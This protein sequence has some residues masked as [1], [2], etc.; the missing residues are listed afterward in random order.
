M[1]V[2]RYD[3]APMSTVTREDQDGFLYTEAVTGRTGVLHYRNADGSARRELRLP[4]EAGSPQTLASMVG[5]PVVVTHSG[6][7]VNKRTAKS[8]TV[9]TLISARFDNGLTYNSMVIHDAA[10]QQAAKTTHPELSQG[11]RLDLEE[12]SGYY[13]AAA[14]EISDTP[15]QGFEPFDYIQRNLRV[16]HLALVPKG[17]AGAVARL[18][19]DGDEELST[20]EDRKMPTIKLANG[21]EVEVVEEVAQHVSALQTRMDGAEAS[22]STTKGTLAAIT[23]DRDALKTQVDGIDDKLK[24]ARLDAADELRAT[25]KLHMSVA[26]KVTEVEGKT[27]TEVKTAF[28]KAVS[29]TINL[30]GLDDAGIN[31]AFE[32][33]I[34]Q[35]PAPT[36]RTPDRSRHI[37]GKDKSERQD[38]AEDSTASAAEQR[39]LVRLGLVR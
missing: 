27:D 7:M 1:P 39:M 13:S 17:R 37:G 4:E 22:L 38:S 18:N 36:D 10:G 33:A 29:P 8:R 32:F 11:Y 3:A 23:A 19:L 12:R 25:A 9:G 28:V 35:N 20:D 30:D 31:G 2:L 6:G 15:K 5:K 26:H 16:N 24:Q 34:A 14:N 21:V